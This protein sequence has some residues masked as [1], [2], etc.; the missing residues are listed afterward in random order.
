MSPMRNIC[1]MSLHNIHTNLRTS[2]S[3]D[4]E[5]STHNKH[6]IILMNNISLKPSIIHSLCESKIRGYN[7]NR[8]NIKA[9][10]TK[11]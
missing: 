11:K 2:E 5:N 6:S 7:K 4:K 9:M 1:I 10:K 3:Y 8:I